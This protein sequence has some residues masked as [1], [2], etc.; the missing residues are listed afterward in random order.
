[1]VEE[2]GGVGHFNGKYYMWMIDGDEIFAIFESGE[3]F[4]FYNDQV[5]WIEFVFAGMF[6]GK[7]L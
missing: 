4:H 3:Y 2:P 6:L 1:M 5:G 7:M